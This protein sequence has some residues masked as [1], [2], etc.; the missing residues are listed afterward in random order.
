M[1]NGNGINPGEVWQSMQEYGYIGA[2]IFDFYAPDNDSLVYLIHTRYL[3]CQ[4]F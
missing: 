2:T 1:L 4:M 3:G